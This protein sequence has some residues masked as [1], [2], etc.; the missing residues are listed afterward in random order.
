[1]HRKHCLSWRT[2]FKSGDLSY[3]AAYIPYCEGE[4]GEAAVLTIIA[5][6]LISLLQL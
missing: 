2:N 5:A 6:T 4:N 3:P 1:M